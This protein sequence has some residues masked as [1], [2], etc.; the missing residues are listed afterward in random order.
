[1]TTNKS[2]RQ[3][4]IASRLKALKDI[5]EVTVSVTD[6]EKT[7]KIS[8]KRHHVADFLFVWTDKNHYVGYFLNAKGGKSHAIISLWTPM[9]CVKFMVM[10][11]NFVELGAKRPD[12]TI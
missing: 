8:H 2:S 6:A 5:D 4:K 9:E 7:I 3:K 1:M 10:Y 12:P 11:L